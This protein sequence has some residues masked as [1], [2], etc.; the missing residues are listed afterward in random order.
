MKIERSGGFGL[1]SQAK[2]LKGAK[3]K[4]EKSLSAILE[5]LSTGKS[6]NRASDNAA[7]LAISERLTTQVRGY[8]MA[9]RNVH[10]AMSALNISEGA[11]N[12]VTDLLQRQRTL[13]SRARN[14]TMNDE[15][16]AALDQEFQ[17]LSKE[18]DRISESTSF[19]GQKTTNGTELGS[20]DAEIV[21][22]ANGESVGMPSVNISTGALGSSGSEIRSVAGA[23]AAM[24]ALDLAIDNVIGQ[25]TEIGT[26]TNRFESIV[27]T[28]NA[29]EVNTQA[30]ES[31]IRD[32]DMAEGISQMVRDQL[33]SSTGT[34]AFDMFNRISS[35]HVQSLLE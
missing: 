13:A 23:E 1:E 34:N 29:A 24:G 12:Q 26:A 19:N 10:D 16:R 27:N 11:S 7:G 25:R 6:I 28:L 30:A 33:L 20:G 18:I 9:G 3:E 2:R 5:K 21:A 22:G 15:N 14:G 4:S 8:K 35:D 31:A 32:Q 17:Q